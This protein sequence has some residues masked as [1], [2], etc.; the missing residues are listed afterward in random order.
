MM[1]NLPGID[2]GTRQFICSTSTFLSVFCTLC[3]IHGTR[4]IFLLLN[5]DIDAD[6]KFSKRINFVSPVVCSTNSVAEAEPIPE[7]IYGGSAQDPFEAVKSRNLIIRRLVCKEQIAHWSKKHNHTE[8]MMLIADDVAVTPSSFAFRRKRTTLNSD[9]SNFRPYSST[10]SDQG[11]YV[12]EPVSGTTPEVL[13]TR[14]GPVEIDNVAS[15]SRLEVNDI[16]F[17][18]T[19]ASTDMD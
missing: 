9:A 1:F 15:F 17:P 16:D 18:I 12:P 2:G 6:H 13:F 4:S 7:D 10:F 11:F 3:C 5:Y 14:S 19:P 8:A